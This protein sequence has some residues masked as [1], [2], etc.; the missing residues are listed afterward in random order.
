MKTNTTI[1][2]AMNKAIDSG[3]F[4]K[5]KH[6]TDV[7]F[8]I[9]QP[10]NDWDRPV[11]AFFPNERYSNED[12]LFTSYSHIGQHCACAIAYAD[13]CEEATSEQYADLKAELE[14]LGYNLNV[15][16]K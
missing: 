16:N 14:G 13:E 1:I 9:E 4:E 7:R 10:I 12:G 15:L 5:D 11:F 8:L 6:V 2:D 3:Y